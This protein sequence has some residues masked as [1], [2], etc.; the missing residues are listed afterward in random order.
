VELAGPV[1]KGV[2][3][4]DKFL[5]EIP[6]LRLSGQLGLDLA[7]EQIS[8]DLQALIFEAPTFEDGLVLDDL[9]G[10]RLPLTVKGPLA[11]P[12]VGVDFSK[13]VREAARGA[14]KEQIKS[15]QNRVLER[16]GIGGGAAGGSVD[17]GATAPLPG[18]N[19]A[20]A[21]GAAPASGETATPPPPKKKPSS[22]DRVRGVLDQLLKPPPPE[23]E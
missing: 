11:S 19:V 21:D 20:P 10:A 12:K 7:K 1:S 22:G 14:A 13:L 2:L 8:G 9:A 6:F 16:L 23:S 3:T 17:P 5:A 18:D 4:T 15:L